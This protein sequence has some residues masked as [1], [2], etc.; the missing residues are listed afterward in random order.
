VPSCLVL[1]S[2][3]K[4]SAPLCHSFHASG[5][6][7]LRQPL[8]FRSP[9]SPLPALLTDEARVWPVMASKS[10]A[11]GKLL[12][13]GPGHLSVTYSDIYV[14]FPALR[15]SYMPEE[16][17]PHARM[18]ATCGSGRQ[19]SIPRRGQAA[20]CHQQQ[21]A[22][23]S[24][25]VC[26]AGR[27]ELREHLHLCDIQM[28]HAKA[29]TWQQ[30]SRGAALAWRCEIAVVEAAEEERSVSWRKAGCVASFCI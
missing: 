11:G 26:T 16:P 3:G 7:V 2:H 12:L 5:I 24:S 28:Q 9:F 22:T 19:G 13:L 17:C 20:G 25:S 4:G 27:P 6:A 23:S 10:T 30:C 21:D 29:Q 14:C 1:S 15:P 18:R 8:C